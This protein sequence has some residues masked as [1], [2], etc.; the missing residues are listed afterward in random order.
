LRMFPGKDDGT[1]QKHII[2]LKAAI[3][4]E[5]KA[6]QNPPTTTKPVDVKSEPE[7]KASPAPVVVVQPPPTPP[8]PPPK[9][10]TPGWVCG[11]VGGGVAAVGIG[12]GVGLGVGLSGNSYPSATYSGRVP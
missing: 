11:V 8:P 6:Q 3:E 10:G 9:K 12:L 5:G 1:V 4:A 7:P 2:A